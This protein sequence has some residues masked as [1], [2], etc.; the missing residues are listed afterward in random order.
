MKLNKI[1]YIILISLLIILWVI[2][3]DWVDGY[4]QFKQYK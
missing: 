2:V 3:L 4:L 1:Y